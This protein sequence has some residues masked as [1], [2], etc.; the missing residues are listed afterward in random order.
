MVDPKFRS[1][2]RINACSTAIQKGS[3]NYDAANLE[4]EMPKQ[5]PRKPSRPN[6]RDLARYEAFANA[7]LAVGQPTYLNAERSAIQAGYKN[8]YAEH[9]GYELLGRVGVQEVMRRLRDERV[10]LSTVASPVEILEALSLQ[11]RTL[12]NVLVDEQGN[13]LPLNKLGNEKA[14]A[15]AGVKETRRTIMAGDDVI[16][17]TR[18]EYK[19]VDRVKVAEIL[20][21][22]H[23]L[24][25]KNNRQQN[26]DNPQP[27]VLMTAKPLTLAE[28]TE[29]AIELQAQ[30]KLRQ[31]EVKP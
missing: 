2:G 10:K 1:G 16:N 11:L 19:L 27:L 26:P 23:G 18:L 20:A 24:F 5:K 28:W 30:M 12:P 3:C 17:E 8:T 13:W 9:R 14:Q 25:E 4:A 6:R 22:H 21:K 7:Y 15:I 31:Q 29:Q